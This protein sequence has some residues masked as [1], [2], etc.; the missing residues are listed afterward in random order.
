[1]KSSA[2]ARQEIRRAR[3]QRRWTG[4]GTWLMIL[5]AIVLWGMANY[6]GARYY[7][8]QHM[9]KDNILE[10]SQL[11]RERVRLIDEPVEI[12]LMLESNHRDFVYVDNLLREYK[13]L[14]P[15]L[16]ITRVDPEWHRARASELARTYVLRPTDENED[17]R[18]LTRAVVFDANGVTRVVPIDQVVLRAVP[19]EL[20]RRQD[21]KVIERHVAQRSRKWYNGEQAFTGALHAVTNRKETKVY[22]LQGNGE[23]DPE[24][25]G[26]SVGYGSAGQRL[27]MD[28]LRIESLVVGSVTRVPEDCGLLVIAGPREEIASADLDMVERYLESGGRLLVMLDANTKSGLEDRLLAW[29]I[30][31]GHGVVVDPVGRGTGTLTV[32]TYLPH[33]VTDG[34]DGY[35]VSFMLP[36]PVGAADAEDESVAVTTLLESRRSSWVES[37]GTIAG[38]VFD[39][40]TDEPGPI[41]L[42]VA[43][44]HGKDVDDPANARLVVFGDSFF[45]QNSQRGGALELLGRSAAWLLDREADIQLARRPMEEMRLSMGPE[46]TAQLAVV[47]LAGIPGLAMLLGG[48]VWL[49]RRN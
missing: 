14:N 48:M 22:F 3:R 12:T 36:R 47:L 37:D 8:R 46:K 2:V 18:E 45:L 34:L 9:A 35:A 32:D 6:I 25:F 29:G 41:S 20:E 26:D 7:E 40:K 39:P 43:A 49:R 23:R 31:V 27:E 16:R 15:N 17:G 13:G 42:A 11:T 30:R 4:M 19:T 24:A 21:T 33:P 10:L 5:L 44:I 1:M 28:N 38:A